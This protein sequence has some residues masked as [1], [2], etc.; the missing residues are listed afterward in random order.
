LGRIFRNNTLIS[1]IGFQLTNIDVSKSSKLLNVFEKI[2]T[3][4]L[5]SGFQNYFE[6]CSL[7]FGDEIIKQT[8]TE[9]VSRGAYDSRQV[10][11]LIEYFFKLRTT[12]FEGKYFSTG[13]IFTKS[14]DMF[15]GTF[16]IKRYGSS[17]KLSHPF[18]ISI[19]DKIDKRLWYWIDGKTSFLLGNK[20]LCF[21]N[22]FILNEE[23]SKSNF[24]ETHS[25]AL[26]LKVK[27]PVQ[28][29]YGQDFIK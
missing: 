12:S 16:D 20:N 28:L 29:I 5:T 17:R 10:R 6:D 1:S 14:A 4:Q 19:T 13:A 25:L 9:Y 3:H 15:D 27:S 24:L 7:I 23:Y 8:I 2:L 11:H 18:Y 21:N 22:L 26:T